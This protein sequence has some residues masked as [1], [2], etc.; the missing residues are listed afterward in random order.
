MSKDLALPYGDDLQTAP[1]PAGAQVADA[2]TPGP[3]SPI[4]WEQVDEQLRDHALPAL[5]SRVTPGL[6]V[7]LVT[8]DATRPSPRR[9]LDPLREA[10]DS[11]GVAY[12]VVVALGRHRPMSPDGLRQHLG[13]PAAHQTCWDED[14]P[15]WPLGLTNRGT[16]IELHPLLQGFDLL[17]LVGFVEPTYL[18]GFSG[19]PKLL[20]PGCA[21]AR[22]I[23]FNHTLILLTGPRPAETEGNEVYADLVE[24]A[25]AAVPVPFLLCLSLDS[26]GRPTG[27]FAGGWDAHA[28]ARAACRDGLSVAAGDAFDVVIASPG[29][30]PYDVDMVQAKKALPA[31]TRA[32]RPGGTVVLL[33]RCPRGWGAISPDRDA[34]APDGDR[35]LADLAERRRQGYVDADWA[36][37]SPAVMFWHVRRKARL[38]IVTEMADE[39]RGTVAEG[40]SSLAEALDLVPEGARGAHLGVLREGRR[41]I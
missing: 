19:G 13:V 28:D 4:S 40:V 30:T 25:K 10:L 12:E 1:V 26:A 41:A 33:G 37:L 14:T 2:L 27:L 23:S 6:R 7:G 15:P 20:F 16:P 3:R 32:V 36:A 18:A 31:A 29:A 34:L 38:I 24:A 8:V 9:L 39:L 17:A 35:R 11:A 22:A 5:L 21:S